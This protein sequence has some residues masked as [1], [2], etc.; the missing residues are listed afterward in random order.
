[1]TNS[2]PTSLTPTHN[3]I[4]ILRNY[5]V[6]DHIKLDLL[7]LIDILTKMSFMVIMAYLVEKSFVGASGPLDL[8]YN[9]LFQKHK[10]MGMIKMTRF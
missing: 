4:V 3:H 9:D 2:F 1:M 10:I 5:C 6:I 7:I 8:I